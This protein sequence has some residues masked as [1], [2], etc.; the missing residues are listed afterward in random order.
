MGEEGQEETWFDEKYPKDK[1]AV[2]AWC[3]A[4]VSNLLMRQDE[5]FRKTYGLSKFDSVRAAELTVVGNQIVTTED[6]ND[7][8]KSKKQN[9]QANVQELLSKVEQG[10]IV[11]K[12]S[13]KRSSKIGHVGMFA[14]F[15]TNDKDE[16]THFKIFGGNQDDSLNIT[17]YP[18][19]LFG[20]AN[21]VQAD[22]LTKEEWETISALSVRDQGR[23][24]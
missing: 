19:E 4:F 8:I 2:A 16:V 13:S 20:G 6:F 3:A 1:G 15:E 23:T 11:F 14:G 12:K 21:R 10:D 24:R 17:R 5:K 9:R 7:A 18:I 22:L